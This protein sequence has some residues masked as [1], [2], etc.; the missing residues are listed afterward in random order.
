[1]ICTV[2]PASSSAGETISTLSFAQRCKDI[3][4]KF[5][6]N[7]VENEEGTNEPEELDQVLIREISAFSEY[8]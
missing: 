3:H 8:Q 5:S 1:M 6:F 7:D 2:S 4:F